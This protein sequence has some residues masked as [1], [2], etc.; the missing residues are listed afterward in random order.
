M[1]YLLDTNAW[2]AYLRQ[3]NVRLVQRFLQVDPR[4]ILAL[5]DIED[6]IQDSERAGDFGQQFVEPALSVYQQNDRRAGIK[7][8]INDRLGSE[9]IEEKSYPMADSFPAPP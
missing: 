9:I 8:R 4:D 3:N 6:Q 2:I 1:I 7:R 5:W